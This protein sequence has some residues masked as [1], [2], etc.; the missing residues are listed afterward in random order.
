MLW[1]RPAHFAHGGLTGALHVIM[2][3]MRAAP[4]IGINECL[5]KLGRPTAVRQAIQATKEPHG[6]DRTAAGKAEILNHIFT[7]VSKKSGRGLRTAPVST[8]H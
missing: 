5:M 1:C 2:R 3:P 8:S 4:A 6:K 7:V